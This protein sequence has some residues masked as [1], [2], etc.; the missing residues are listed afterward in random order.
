MTTQ[1]YYD[2][3]EQSHS[4][5]NN[6]YIGTYSNKTDNEIHYISYNINSNTINTLAIFEHTYQIIHLVASPHVANIIITVYYNNNSKKQ[7]ATVWQC[8]LPNNNNIQHPRLDRIF[9]LP[10]LNGSTVTSMKFNNTADDNINELAIC[11]TDG[12]HIYR[13][14]DQTLSSLSSINGCTLIKHNVDQT[15]EPT[16][17]AWNPHTFNSIVVAYSNN[18][19]IQYNPLNNSIQY[20]YKIHSTAGNK[21]QCID[22]NPNKQYTMAVAGTDRLIRIIDVSTS[23]E[24]LTLSNHTYHIS[25]IAYNRIYDQLLLSS[26]TE[27]INLWSLSTVSS[28]SSSSNIVDNDNDLTA[29]N[30]NTNISD[31]LIESYTNEHTDSVYSI[32]WSVNDAFTF[33][34]L[35][36]DGRFVIHQMNQ[37]EKYKL[38]L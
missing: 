12:V 14:A 35:S 33:A 8:I 27:T 1:L 30:N 25:N 13:F 17:V 34:S 19:V 23:T 11:N 20:Q 6:Y 5:T 9:D 4:N 38:L 37:T 32:C 31:R 2:N 28:T 24:L 3:N 16:A 22:Y 26:D 29:T 36:Y 15:I 21:I 7:Q 10:N 18:T